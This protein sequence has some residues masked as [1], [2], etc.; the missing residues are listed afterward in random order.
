VYFIGKRF[1]FDAA[2]MLPGLPGDHKC[3][4]LH[5]H[6]Y[7]V[8]L[9]LG[10]APG[11][12]LVLPGFVADFGAL[13]PFR[14]YLAESFDHRFLNE[15]SALDC[16]PTAENLARHFFGWCVENVEPSVPGRITAVRVWETPSS[17]AEYR[18]VL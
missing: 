7:T 5:G 13:S 9:Q 2:H 1:S 11:G 12:A 8:E 18:G 16:E 6:T 17:W 10:V 15:T 4:R 3:A 14:D